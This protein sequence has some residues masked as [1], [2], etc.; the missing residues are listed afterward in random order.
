MCLELSLDSQRGDFSLNID[1]TLPP[2]GVSAL[3][4]PSGSGKTSCLRSMAGLD[5][6]A[7]GYFSL[8]GEV[9]QDDKNNIWLDCYQREIG[10]VFQEASLF[11]HLNVEKNLLFG[12]RLVQPD[13]RQV[14]ISDTCELLSI[15][16]LLKRRVTSLSGGERQRVAIAR[17]LLSS[18]KLLLMDE[19]LSA[20][21]AK[22]KQ[23][24]IPY[25]EQLHRQLSIPVVYVSHDIEEV[26][27]L[28]DYMILLEK[29]Q[30]VSQAYVSNFQLNIEPAATQHYLKAV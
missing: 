18:P 13:K 12:Y 10:Y 28:A 16:H 2:S 3:F 6:F 17:A 8:N 20:L 30:V 27:Q 4:G 19:P 21:D 9:W 15:S 22:L 11:P 14:S 29:G 23:E 24:I 26:K 5:R 7:G 25:L 1:I